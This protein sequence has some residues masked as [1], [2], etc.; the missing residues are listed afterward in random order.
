[1]AVRLSPQVIISD[2]TPQVDGVSLC[3]ALRQARMGTEIYILLLVDM[4]DDA[5]VETAFEAGADDCLNKPVSMRDVRTRMRAARRL[6]GVHDERARER[7]EMRRLAGELAI[8]NRRLEEAVLTDPL[9]GAPNRRFGMSRIEGEWEGAKTTGRPFACLVIDIDRFKQVNDTYGHDVGDKVLKHT[10]DLLARSVRRDDAVSRHGGEEFLVI[11]RAA[12]EAEALGG[13]ERLRR[14]LEAVPFRDGEL[15]IP[16]TASI[17]VA[18]WDP[19]MSSTDELIKAAD[20][21]VYAAKEAGRNRSCVFRGDSGAS[22][23]H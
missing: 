3:K 8:A 7:E 10:A 6:L 19:Q 13:A 12:N 18:M 14:A 23:R 17:G 1:M 9:T 11:L 22:G 15:C 21:A 4:E 16:L 5:R 20:R 2:W